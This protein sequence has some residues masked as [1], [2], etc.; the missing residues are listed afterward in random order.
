[1][2]FNL[3]T[4]KGERQKGLHLLSAIGVR[5]M[6]FNLLTAKGERQKGLNLLSD[7]GARKKGSISCPI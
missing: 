2:W 3:L 5:Q 6:W 7:I 4:A 1:M